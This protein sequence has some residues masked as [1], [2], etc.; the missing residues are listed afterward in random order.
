MHLRARHF[1]Y[2]VSFQNAIWILL[3]ALAED[4]LRR[5]ARN[6]ALQGKNRSVSAMETKLDSLCQE[7]KQL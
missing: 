4:V 2:E 7:Q 5:R 1:S 3:P 6:Y